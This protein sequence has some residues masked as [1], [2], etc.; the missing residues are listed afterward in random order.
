MRTRRV[1]TAENAERAEGLT[2][3]N[4]ENAEG[5]RLNSK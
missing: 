3:E 2:A 5:S 1:S 4:A